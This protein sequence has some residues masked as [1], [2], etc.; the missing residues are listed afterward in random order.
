MNPAVTQNI[1]IDIET[2]GPRPD[3]LIVSIGAICFNS[4]PADF[5]AGQIFS[6]NPAD[7]FH[8]VLN[9]DAAEKENR[10]VKDAGMVNWWKDQGEAY[11]KLT[12]L[13]RAPAPKPSTRVIR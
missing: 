13:I 4:D 3:G 10:F 9:F 1:M 2:F 12:A 6:G 5:S 11:S 7:M 8:A